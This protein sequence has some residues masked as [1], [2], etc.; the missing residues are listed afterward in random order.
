MTTHMTN[1]HWV[2]VGRSAELAGSGP[3][4]ANAGGIDLVLL[5][6]PSGLKAYE[7]RCPHQGAL[8]GEG[9]LDDGTLVCRNHRWRFDVETG[10]RRGGAQCL[11]A[12]PVREEGGTIEADVS[13]IAATHVS[14]AKRK[15]RDLPGPPS[16]PIV[17]SA[18]LVDSA[19]VH[20]RLEEWAKKF[21]TPFK[22][23]FGP[24][25]IVAFAD[26]PSMMAILRERPEMFRRTSDLAPAFRELGIAGVFSAE[27]AAWRPQR[28]LS[29]EALSHRHLRGFYPALATVAERLRKRWAAAAE[30]GDTLDLPDELKRFT[31]DITTQLVFGYD[32]NTLEQ[33]GDVIQDK[34]ELIFPT[35]NRR[36]FSVFPTWR[37]IRSPSDRRVDRAVADIRT[38]IAGLVDKARARVAASPEL[39]AHPANLLE[40]MIA[41]RDENGKPFDDEVIHGNAMTMLLAGEDTTAYTL[42]WAVHHLIDAPG[43]VGALRSELDGELGDAVVPPSIDAAGRLAYAGAVANEA[44]RLRPVAPMLGLEALV[45][46]T[47]GDVEIPKGTGVLCLT[48][49]PALD[50]ANFD[51]PQAFRPSRWIDVQRAGAHDSSALLPFGSGPRICPGRTLALLEMKVLLATLYKNFEVD[52]VGAADAVRELFAFTMKPAS[53]EV[54]MRA[55]A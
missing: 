37:W 38:W 19:A 31:V 39:E 47:V 20:L 30:R 40:A 24:M 51:D 16:L 10:A 29:M 48:R 34:L 8:L 3:Y 41:T 7:G 33:T 32:I 28:R 35:L 15:M 25:R 18:H 17:G 50:K 12:C 21:G 43:E 42:A 45:D 14:R 13:P 2:P 36:L 6:A 53:L 1:T 52:R 44:M 23:R 26:V 46:T 5:R 9:E 22:F 54:R 4:V 55:R 49:Q 27:G 11:R